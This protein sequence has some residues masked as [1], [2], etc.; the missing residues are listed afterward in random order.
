MIS[1]ECHEGNTFPTPQSV[2]VAP[3][4]VLRMVLDGQISGRISEWPQLKPAIAALLLQAAEQAAEIER[5]E[6]M[7]ESRLRAIEEQRLTIGAL[8]M[9]CEDMGGTTP[10]LRKLGNLEADLAAAERAREE[11]C[12]LLR[13]C[14]T[15]AKVRGSLGV[16]DC[17]DNHG[18]PYQSA[19]LAAFLAANG[20]A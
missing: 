14:D 15:V 17:I 12:G 2:D 5:L 18:Q 6:Q 16:S 13:D 9:G 10:I 8:V 11:A 19:H 20:G 1:S 4:E 7:A 3:C